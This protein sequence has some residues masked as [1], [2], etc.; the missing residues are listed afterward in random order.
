MVRR[1][2]V[3]GLLVLSA[4][5]GS[6]AAARHSAT[7][8]A[9]VGQST[10][11]PKSTLPAPSTKPGS[12]QETHA[13]LS[14]SSNVGPAGTHIA[15]AATDCPAF[16]GDS[17]SVYWHNAYNAAHPAQAGNR[18]LVTLARRQNSVSDVQSAYTV[19]TDDPPGRSVVV[20]QCGGLGGN[21][22]GYFTVTH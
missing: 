2:V 21:A 13:R 1:L 7:S 19:T 15:I 12:S 11:S 17:Q 4:C 3:V 18:G 20:V 9:A 16:A 5:N 8:Q 10:G 6:R 22:V 14:L